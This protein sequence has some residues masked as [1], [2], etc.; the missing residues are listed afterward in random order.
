MIDSPHSRYRLPHWGWFLLATVVL[1]IAGV[2]HS[3]WMSYHREQQVIQM[4]E[5]WG[6][7]VATDFDG[8]TETVGPEWLRRLVGQDRMKRFKVFARV[9]VVDLEPTAVTDAEIMYLNELG[10]LNVLLLSGTPVTDAGVVHLRGLA[11]LR[12]LNLY[13]TAVT[14]STLARLSKLLNL[15]KL[16]LNNT[17]ATDKGIEELRRALPDCEIVQSPV[18]PRPSDGP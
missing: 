12:E 9:S 6:G 5:G 7:S 4:I 18:T 16:C 10:N 1:V 13:G 8:E 15:R 3:V 11:N 17:T 14:D 2:S